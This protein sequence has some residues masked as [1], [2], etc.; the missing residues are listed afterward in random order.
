MFIIM[1]DCRAFRIRGILGSMLYGAPIAEVGMV[2]NSKIVIAN[3]S[4]HLFPLKK[5]KVK[6][7]QMA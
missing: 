3:V 6:V 1:S 7:I 4:L 5:R 2:S